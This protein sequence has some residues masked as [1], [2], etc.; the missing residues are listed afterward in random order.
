MRVKKGFATLGLALL[1][2]VFGASV[3]TAEMGSLPTGADG[4]YFSF[5]GGGVHQNAPEVVAYD[6]IFFPPAIPAGLIASPK[7][8]A[9]QDGGF[10]GI[11][12]GFLLG[13]GVLPFGIQ[14]ARL[15]ATFSAN[16]F[17]D[18]KISNPGGAIGTNN[19]IQYVDGSGNVASAIT[20]ISAVQK[21][22]VYDGSLSL[23]GEL[24]RAE[25]VDLTSS[26]ELFVRAREDTTKTSLGVTFRNADVDS[27]YFGTLIA[28]Q[29]EFKLGNGLSFATDFGAGVYVADADANF[30]MNLGPVQQL[31]D[32][33]TKVGFR[34]R[35]GG[36]LKAE[37]AQGVAASLFGTVNYWSDMAYARMPGA[38]DRSPSRVAFDS[39]IE[40][41][42]GARL[43]VALGSI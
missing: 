34:G 28:L 33:E 17:D 27:W 16:I 31:S 20:P 11:D 30:A 4:F 18:G 1:G 19:S 24:A 13:D 8:V 12:L 5:F 23:K 37:V 41:K 38:T 2:H 6:R 39:L 36:A 21:T 42:F 3:A 10:A 25:V 15:E 22:E 43:S 7:S 32:K 29:P 35:L 26:L 40:A 9:S 14:N